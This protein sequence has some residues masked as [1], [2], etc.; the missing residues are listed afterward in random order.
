SSEGIRVTP[1][2]TYPVPSVMQGST[3]VPGVTFT[4]AIS[5]VKGGQGLPS[6]ATPKDTGPLGTLGN[7]AS[8][9]DNAF[10]DFLGVRTSAAPTPTGSES[11][12]K[13]AVAPLG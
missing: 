6:S 7:I 4:G 12:F 8:A 1:G 5:Q 10:A 2:Y 9:A 11:P 13:E 3:L